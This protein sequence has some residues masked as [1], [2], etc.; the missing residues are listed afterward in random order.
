MNP[1][2]N[3]APSSES[4]NGTSATPPQETCIYCGEPRP[5][6]R[7]HVPPQSIFPNPKPSNL[8]TVPARQD[9]NGGFKLDDEY[10][11]TF[12]VTGSYRS[13]AARSLWDRKTIGSPNAES[14]RQILRRSMKDFEIRSPSGLY[15]GNAPAL[16]LDARRTL[17]IAARI[18]L[19]LWWHHYRTRPE[20]SIKILAG[21]LWS[22]DGMEHILSACQKASIAGDVFAYAHGVPPEDTHQSVW[23]LQFYSS[24]LFL[25]VA[26]RQQHAENE[27]MF[28][29]P[30][31]LLMRRK[32]DG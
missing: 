16:L 28:E 29:V 13:S 5:L 14:I 3:E 6:T 10:F 12:V 31:D 32:G 11:R 27:S 22:L 17:R 21:R 4:D 8:I 19:G 23:F 7:D 18:V 30:R 20:S 15:L 24:L 2:S 25:V 1:K 26:T 9:C